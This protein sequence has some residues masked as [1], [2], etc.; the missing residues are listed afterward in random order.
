M[1]AMFASRLAQWFG[2][3]SYAVYL[4][5]FP[6]IMALSLPIL[7]DVHGGTG[8]QFLAFLGAVVPFTL[9]AAELMHRLVERPFITLGARLAR[10]APKPVP[11]AS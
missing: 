11:P 1:D 6:I 7:R 9:L 5:H 2:A 10:I 4:V 3:R 8:L